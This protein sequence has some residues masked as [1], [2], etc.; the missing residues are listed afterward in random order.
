MSPAAPARSRR[1]TRSATEKLVALS[2][3][4]IK[5]ARGAAEL[6]R[7]LDQAWAALREVPN[8]QQQREEGVADEISEQ[9]LR[10][11]GAELLGDAVVG[12]TDDKIKALVACCFVELLRVFTPDTPFSSGGELHRVFQCLLD[13]L[14]GLGG[15]G[16]GGAAD[17]SVQEHATYVLEN[18]ASMRSSL[19]LLLEADSTRED[20]EDL[21]V[22]QL[23]KTLFGA[24]RADHSAKIESLM[25]N[26]MTNCVEDSDNI[27]QSVI[28]SILAP[29]LSP[30]ASR[31]WDTNNADEAHDEDSPPSRERGPYFVAQQ[32]I[33]RTSDQLETPLAQFFNS[34][35]IDAPAELMTRTSS[36]LKEHVYTLIYEVHHICPAMLLLVLPNV[37]MQLQVDEIATRSDAVIL[38]GRLFASLHADYGQQF[39]KSFRDFLGRFRDASKEIR[40]LMVQASVQIWENKP[41]LG[42]LL[43]KELMERLS[44]P[45]WDV[46]QLVVRELCDFAANNLGLI[47]E[48]CI[49]LVGERMKDK[50]VVIRKETM[51]GLSQVYNAHVTSCLIPDPDAEDDDDGEVQSVPTDHTRKLGW[52]PDYVLKCFAYPQQELKLRVVQLL[53]D[54]LLPKHFSDIKRARVL[55]FTFQSLDATS[56]EAFRR[57]LSDRAKCS[58]VITDF[59]SRRQQ[60]RQDKVKLTDAD[61][62]TQTQELY[63]VLHALFPETN[64]LKRLLEQLVRWKDQS[65]FKHLRTVSDFSESQHGVRTARDQL[66]KCVGSKSQLGEFMKNLC[67]RLA[68]LTINQDII[69]TI[70]SILTD[71]DSHSVKERRAAV[72]VLVASSSALPRMLI[73]FVEDRKLD[74]LLVVKTNESGHNGQS[75][76]EEDDD[77]DMSDEEDPKIVIGVLNALANCTRQ[78]KSD[79]TTGQQSRIVSAELSNSLSRFCLGSFDGGF[80]NLS[81]S[82]E[83]E[84]ARLAA[85][86]LANCIDDDRQSVV[87]LVRKLCGRKQ[88]G[89]LHGQ[90]VACCL[91][92]VQVFVKCCGDVFKTG[93]DDLTAE[94]WT[95]LFQ[96]FLSDA[97]EQAATSKQPS[98]NDRK[99]LTAV[100]LAELRCSA[101]NVAVNVLIYCLK[102][103]SSSTREAR[104]TELTKLL[105]GILR[106]DGKKWGSSPT[107]AA[108]FRIAASCGLLKLM[109][110][111]DIEASITVSEWHL[112][113]FAM[114]DSSEDVRRAFLKKLTSH[115][116]KGSV[117]HPH[118]YLA[119]IALA[120]TE[121]K[122]PL[123]KIAKNLLS[124]AVQRMRSAFEASTAQMSGAIS[125]Q[126]SNRDSSSPHA[127]ATNASTLMVPEYALPYVVHLLAHHPDF[128]RALV[129]KQ[130]PD[131]PTSV[132][133]NSLWGE[134]VAYL[135]FFLGG[136]VSTGPTGSDNIAFL[137]QI[138]DKLSQCHD[139]T[140]PDAVHIYPLLDTAVVLLKKKIKNQSNLKAFPGTIFVPRHLYRV[141]T[142]RLQ[143]SM[144]SLSGVDNDSVARR[145][146]RISVCILLYIVV[147]CLCRGL[148]CLL[149]R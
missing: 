51:T 25:V 111:K 139:A 41:S 20:N 137:L 143:Q 78:W 133:Q 101:I 148:T 68:M 44:D 105:F 104:S 125:S 88:L 31:Q 4:H 5:G 129:D 96:V 128:P 23:F 54:V 116:M 130:T 14:R 11:V 81:A 30:P 61:A 56:K 136:L 2:G 60:Q 115:L 55:V 19:L 10:R 146:P 69:S 36:E 93:G 127:A 70:L 39:P 12:H 122:M 52:I 74:G 144:F 138:I 58:S 113:G 107:A 32:L 53:D 50:K 66:V 57:I 120:A 114:Q 109:R 48:D 76:E 112:L 126:E 82:M 72:E 100:Q 83:V 45:E 75:S 8:L 123:K 99:K 132:L 131:D 77:E 21:L 18:L 94:L 7:R 46:R 6:R 86:S 24:I 80:D 134:Q 121:P 49:R 117:P 141:G 108:K 62:E 3:S 102:D 89:S 16:R 59:V 119:Y 118:K 103:P 149:Y 67:R 26:V 95:V 147:R 98:R 87:S 47:G 22:T 73:P 1:A 65:V 33:Q 28:D 92:S 135:S 43:E 38:M 91:Q 37:C 9:Q 145:G 90:G 13:V 15:D 34:V 79:Q 27:D 110:Q 42:S 84:A 40:L 85:C 142:R 17:E 29:L 35:L 71:S 140:K 97:D 64:N 106:S 124:T 63:D